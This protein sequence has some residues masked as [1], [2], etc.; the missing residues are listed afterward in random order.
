[1][2]IR[3]RTHIELYYVRKYSG[4]RIDNLVKNGAFTH[5]WQRGWGVWKRW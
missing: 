5:T 3:L 4:M 1:M 2:Q